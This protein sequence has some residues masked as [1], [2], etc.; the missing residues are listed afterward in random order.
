MRLPDL[1]LAA[2]NLMRRP[3]FALTA[4]LLLALGAGAN[5]A[6]FSIVRGILLRPLPY[7]AP[8]ELV[9]VWP[10]SFVSNE[11]LG[12]WRDRTRSFQAIAALSPGWMMAFAVDGQEPLKVTGAK[13]SGNFFETLSVRAALG[14]TLD[15]VDA[16]PGRAG[17]AIISAGI[18][19]RQFQSNPAVIGRTVLLDGRPHEVAGVMP[20]GFEFYEPGTDVWVPLPF[21]PSAAAQHRSQFSQAFARLRPGATAEGATAELQALLPDMRRDLAKP[22]RWGHDLRAVGL[23][24]AVTGDV[25]PTLLILLGAV[26]LILL[27]AAINLGTLV[28]GRSIA[29]SREMAVR[30]ALGASR[31][32]LIRHLLAEQALLASLGA[33]AGLALARVALP[34]LVS[35][36][37]PEMPRQSE[38]ALDA[39][40]FAVVFAVT[41][42]VS[43]LLGLVPLAMAA[44]P[45]LQPLLRQTQSTE[46]PARRRALG[47]LVAAQVALAIVLGI[48]AGLM[49]RSVWNLQ[50]VDPG[51]RAAQVL[52]FRLQTTSK[53]TSLATGLP[54]LEQMR[55][56]VRALPGVSHV[57]AIQHLPLSGYNWTARVH[58]VEEP[59]PPGAT[60]DTA[61]WRFVGWE[62]FQTMGIGLRAGRLFTTGDHVNAPGVA[63]VNEAFARRRYGAPAAA[64]GRQIV[65][66]ASG[67]TR[68][69]EIVGVIADVRFQSL[70]QP[71]TP[72]L[73][74]P[75]AQTFMFPMAF[76]VRT[77][78]EPA[79]IAAAVRQ[80]AFAVDPAIPVAELQPLTALIAGSLGRPRLLAML[81]T[82][83]AAAGLALGII[84]VYGVVA[85]RVR[86]RE[87]EFGIRMALGAGP[88][89]IVHAV[90]RQGAGYAAGGL[91]VGLPAAFALTRLMRSVIYGITTHDALTFVALPAAVVGA[92][93]LACAWPAR[94]AG[95]VDPVVTMRA[96]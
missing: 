94:R 8:D 15:A 27:L 96:D 11:E 4:I 17:V 26:G 58:P 64:V 23:Q 70:D 33:L 67:G 30:T 37:P 29:R 52:T 34:A 89:R 6:V 51:F 1:T 36:I 95:R 22:A 32:R 71:A 24:D 69:L 47:A 60:A 53:Y 59:P 2:R 5:A 62:Y 9:A 61:V 39:G 63:I 43:V 65:S 80:A 14:R 74:R 50:Q 46:T 20:R 81:L 12:Y 54:Y 72:E 7:Q 10:T 21:D 68:T 25:R 88:R 45:E 38:I 79:A 19:E 28:L 87:R 16:A 66:E 57:G 42:V 76:V 18:F 92:T 82:V 93:L 85:Y 91:L 56:R 3:G 31:L 44:R 48:G 77:T 41:V 73:Y 90:L 78:G 83:F 75:L 35:R 40:V 86:Q 49:L 84:G 13:T 55:A